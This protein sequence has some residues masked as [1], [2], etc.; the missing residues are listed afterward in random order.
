MR[1]PIGENIDGGSTADLSALLSDKPGNLCQSASALVPPSV[2][3]QWAAS[4][5]AVPRSGAH[6][7]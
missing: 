3:A 4:A 7:G 1:V 5:S 6:A 2:S